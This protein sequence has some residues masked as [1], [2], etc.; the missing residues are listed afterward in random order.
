MDR[1]G[2]A[3]CSA[4]RPTAAAPASRRPRAWGGPRSEVKEEPS[5]KLAWCS[6]GDMS[7]GGRP[8]P[9]PTAPRARTP[10]TRY[11]R[12]PKR[13][14]SVDATRH[15]EPAR[16]G[17]VQVHDVAGDA[18]SSSADAGR[19][20][21]RLPQHP[22]LSA[23]GPADRSRPRAR[24]AVRA[25]LPPERARLP[26]RPA[27]H[28]LGLRRLPAHLPLPARL[29]RRP[30]RRRRQGPG[31]HRQR[32]AGARDGVR[33]LRPG[34]RQRALLPPLRPARG[35]GRGPKAPRR[36]DRPAARVREGAASG[37]IRSSSSTSACVGAFPANGTARC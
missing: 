26:G 24:R 23:R 5:A 19:V 3:L 28:P 35:L 27:L 12:I 29:H 20:H 1:G 25:F 17:P 6:A 8:C 16:H 32:P 30:R 36:Q 21:L 4:Q 7:G 10:R 34:D 18:A 9:R 33:D 2:G 13:P 37:S 14:K 31:D 15:H 11:R 22:G